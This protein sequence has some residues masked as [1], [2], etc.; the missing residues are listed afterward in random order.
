MQNA[1]L[2]AQASQQQE[3]INHL[4]HILA[5][6]SLL[7]E[8]DLARQVPSRRLQPSASA[9]STSS[10]WSSASSPQELQEVILDEEDDFSSL[11][12]TSLDIPTTFDQ[13][14]M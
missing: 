10:K 11:L 1:S 9:A 2:I 7:A 5:R 6:N 13:A 3:V 14:V 4:I 8:T 12:M